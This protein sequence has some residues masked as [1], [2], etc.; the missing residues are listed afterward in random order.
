MQ[1]I[2]LASGRGS[3]LVPLTNYQPKPLLPVANRP[4]LDYLLQAVD[5]VGC[6]HIFV[7]HGYAG[8]QIEQYLTTVRVKCPV[9]PVRA[10]NW[11]KGPLASFLAVLPLLTSDAPV[12]LVPGDLYISAQNLALLTSATAEIALLYD[13]FSTRPGALVQ[14]TASNQIQTLT[15]ALTALPD[16]HPSLPALRASPAFFTQLLEEFQELPS[17]V[18]ALLQHWLTKGSPLYGIPI[19]DPSWFDV[20]T[21]VSLVRLNHYLLT[22]GW[23]PTPLPPGTYVPPD[24]S[25]EGPIQS[26]TLTLGQDSRIQGPVLVGARVRV[27][28][29]CVIRDGTTIGA[30][31]T[32]HANSELARCIILPH[33]QVPPNTD[34]Y[35]AVVDA[36]G[37][38]LR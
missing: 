35:D 5:Q 12:L 37:N 4:L 19:S 28:R 2:I 27:D 3:R 22:T 8:D 33:S 36:R 24:I 21:L 16:H 14:L 38:I 32:I 7:T 23:A 31:V 9:S 13:P 1:A 29:D 20:D 15:S 34:I 11:E 26:A 6:T 17:T 25:M 10:S 30:E 18:F